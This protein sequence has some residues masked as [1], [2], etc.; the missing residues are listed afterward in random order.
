MHLACSPSSLPF[1]LRDC[2]VPFHWHVGQ[3]GCYSRTGSVLEPD[4]IPLAL[5]WEFVTTG[6]VLRANRS[7]QP[8]ESRE[9]NDAPSRCRLESSASYSWQPLGHKLA[10]RACASKACLEIKRIS[11]ENRRLHGDKPRQN[12]KPMTKHAKKAQIQRSLTQYTVNSG[13]KYTEAI[14]T[15]RNMFGIPRVSFNGGFRKGRGGV[16]CFF[17][18]AF[19]G[20]G[21][22]VSRRCANAARA[23]ALVGRL[24][25]DATW[26]DWDVHTHAGDQPCRTASYAAS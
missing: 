13:M 7:C 9:A 21:S 23:A 8:K 20:G 1:T 18:V 25:R 11:S 24:S 5:S 19:Q 15:C 17:K 3:S 12:P 22:S 16:E 10:I 26:A 4:H 2:P 6:G 14:L